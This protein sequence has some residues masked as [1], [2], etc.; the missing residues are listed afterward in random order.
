VPGRIVFGN[1]Y[2]SGI[3][4]HSDNSEKVNKK[5]S[6]MA[7]PPNSSFGRGVETFGSVKRKPDEFVPAE[8]P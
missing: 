5:T 2:I 1:N 6:H 4:E 7:E 3:T 8:L